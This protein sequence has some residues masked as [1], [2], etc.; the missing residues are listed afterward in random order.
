[1]KRKYKDYQWIL[2]EIKEETK[3]LASKDRES[4]LSQNLRDTGKADL[5]GRLTAMK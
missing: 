4:T 2:E 1:M 3:V 5:R